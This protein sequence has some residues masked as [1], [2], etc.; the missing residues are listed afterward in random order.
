MKIY[1]FC[2]FHIYVSSINSHIWNTIFDAFFLNQSQFNLTVPTFHRSQ[3]VFWAKKSNFV[4]ICKYLS[5]TRWSHVLRVRDWI[6]LFWP[7]EKAE[8]LLSNKPQT[9]K[10]CIYRVVFSTASGALVVVVVWGGSRP[11]HPIPS[12]PEIALSVLNCSM[13]G[14]PQPNSLQLF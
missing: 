4:P 14:Q 8:S 13:R 3:F 11:S 1:F 10:L 6:G 5:G 7:A 12:H 9:Y 2:A